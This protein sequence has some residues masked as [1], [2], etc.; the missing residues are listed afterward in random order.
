MKNTSTIL[1]AATLCVLVFV[2]SARAD[3]CRRT[4][5]VSFTVESGRCKDVGGVNSSISTCT[6]TICADGTRLIGSY[7]GHYS[8]NLFGCNCGGGCLKGKWEKNFIERH[9]KY[10]IRILSSKWN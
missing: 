6:I 10:K 2:G 5:N 7:C 1:L 4:K 3:C 8:C 9:P